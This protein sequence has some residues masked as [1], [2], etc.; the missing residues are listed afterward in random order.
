MN[1]SN[2]VDQM[3]KFIEQQKIAKQVAL[4]MKVKMQ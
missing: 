3:K 2:T 1:K 4:Q